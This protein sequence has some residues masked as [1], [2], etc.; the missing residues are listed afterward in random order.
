MNLTLSS[1]Y[2]PYSFPTLLKSSSFSTLSRPFCSS[3]LS[4]P[5]TCVKPQVPLFLRPPIYST[6]LCELKKWH[7]WAKGVAF[8]IGSTFVHSDN[9]RD[10]SILFREMKWLMEDAVEDHSM[11]VDDERV[12]MR[13]GIDELYCLWKQRIHERRPFQYVVGCEH[14]RDL[15]LSV[16]E[17][18]L[19]PRPETELIVDFV[20]DVVS[21]NEDL[22]S[23]VWADLGTG[24]GALAIGIG[25]V[26][27]SEGGRVVATDLS[28]VAVAVAAY[29]VQRYCL[30]DKIELR[31]GSWFE[32]LKDM[33]GKLVGLVSN[34]PYIPSKDISGLQAEVGRHEPRVALDG[35]TDGMDALLHLC[36]GA[37]LMLK[38][39]GFFAF[40]QDR[41]M[42]LG[43]SSG[44]CTVTSAYYSM[45]EDLNDQNGYGAIS[46]EGTSP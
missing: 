11:I 19:I 33:E 13:I 32:P 27:R 20:Y 24:S 37:G 25:R 16:Q 17:G 41:W 31:E 30:Q 23:G 21:E 26:L 15:V 34:P 29:N 42:W 10:S 1:V 40:E 7:D 45:W 35:G 14:W 4:S 46:G 22:K 5:P 9:G 12:K 44:E 18:V 43:V 6:K 8:S 3:A 39:G 28:P 38:P 36:D 2:R